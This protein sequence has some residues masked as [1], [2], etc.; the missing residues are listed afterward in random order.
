MNTIEARAIAAVGEAIYRDR[1]QREL[2]QTSRGMFVA[3]DVNSGD[4]V[5]SD[6]DID[7]IRG[8][9]AKSASSV[10]HLIRV[11]YRTAHQC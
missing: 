11:G 10:F 2:E 3:I 1:Y 6:S 5:L 8:V 4:V 9:L 7:A